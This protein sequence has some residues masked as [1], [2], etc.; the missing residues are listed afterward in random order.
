LAAGKLFAQEGA[1]VLLVDLDERN[2]CEAVKSIENGN[3]SY[4]VADVSQPEQVEKFILAAKDR[5]GR[6]DIYLSNAGIEGVVKKIE[7]Y[8]IE[9]FDRVFSVNVRGAWLGLKYAIPEMKKYGGGSIII[10]SSYAGVK[11][12]TGM[13]AYVASKHAAVGLMRAAA[14]ECA[15]SGIR[16]NTVNP[17]PIESRMMHSIIDGISRKTKNQTKHSIRKGIPLK[18]YGMPEEVAQLM[19]FL[20]SDQSLYCTGGVYMIDG[21]ISA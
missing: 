19:L 1:S 8:P 7:E 4:A 2:L 14:L 15:K 17:G 21:G 12:T 13:S 18:R 9:V 10:T 16:V 11:G 3:I 6:F 5:Y 20:A